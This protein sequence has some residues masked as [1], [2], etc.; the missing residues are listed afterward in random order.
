[1]GRQPNRSAMSLYICILNAHRLSVNFLTHSLA[2]LQHCRL[3]ILLVLR[4]SCCLF[5]S[6]YHSVPLSLSSFIPSF[7][8]SLLPFSASPSLPPFLPSQTYIFIHGSIPPSL[9]LSLS[10][11]LPPSFFLSLSPFISLSLSPFIALYLPPPSSLP[12]SLS[13]SLPPSLPS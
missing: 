1:M 5:F 2:A 3:L 7:L 13:P 11:S 10:L 8:H 12:P 4:Y 6:R 9:L